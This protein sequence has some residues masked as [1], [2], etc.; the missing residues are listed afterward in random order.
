MG[1]EKN[2][3]EI[4]LLC[5]YNKEDNLIWQFSEA[6]EMVPGKWIFQITDNTKVIYQKEFTVELPNSRPV[7]PRQ[8]RQ[9]IINR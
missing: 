5:K 1:K 2:E 4:D 9:R 8:V 7:G 3:F 6:H